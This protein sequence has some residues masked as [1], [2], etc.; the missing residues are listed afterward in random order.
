MHPMEQALDSLLAVR[1][2]VRAFRPDPV[3]PATVREIFTLAQLAPSNCNAQPWR[4]WV[5]SGEVR[6]Q[7][8]DRLVEAVSSGAPASTEDEMQV[9]AGPYRDLQVACAMEM[10]G[11]MG[12][13]RKDKVARTKAFMRNYELFDAPHVA[14]VGMDRTF[15]IGVA[16]DVGMWL[17]SLLLLFTSRGL[18]ACPM[19]SLRS[20]PVVVRDVLGIPED[21]RIL[22]GVTFG[23][24]D[25]DAPVNRTTQPRSPLDENVRFLG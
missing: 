5:A 1:R 2:S 14:I 19:A 11:H 13:D 25:P 3:D 22:C 4:V 17:Q 24:P 9:F 15:N 6:D 7:L 16:L 18:G 8:R 23:H 21:I 10:Y 12:V 20:H